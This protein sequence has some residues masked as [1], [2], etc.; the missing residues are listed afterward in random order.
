MALVPARMLLLRE[1]LKQE[2]ESKLML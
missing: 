1:L 2:T